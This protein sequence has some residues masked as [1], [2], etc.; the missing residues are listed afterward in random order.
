MKIMLRAHLSIDCFQTR[1]GGAR[2]LA[3]VRT[4][5]DEWLDWEVLEP[6]IKE[7]QALIDVEVQQ[8]DKKLY[9]YEEF[10]TGV[11]GGP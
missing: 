9:G 1:S 6:I 7:Y 4:V 5:V 8:D 11:P 10:A 3:H 2:Y